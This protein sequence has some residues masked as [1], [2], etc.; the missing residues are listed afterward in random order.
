MVVNKMK[1]ELINRLRK[2]RENYESFTGIIARKSEYH[3]GRYALINDLLKD[4]DNKDE[5]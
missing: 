4:F 2:Y 3:Q 1:S 5:K